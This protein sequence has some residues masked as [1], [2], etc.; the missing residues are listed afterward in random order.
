M[1]LTQIALNESEANDAGYSDTQEIRATVFP[2]LQHEIDKL[3]RRAQKLGVPEIDLIKE[4]E[5][6]RTV[7]DPNTDMETQEKWFEVTVDG[8][9]PQ[10]P[11]YKFLATIEHKGGGNVIRLVPGNENVANLQDF[12]NATPDYC[13]HC[14]KRRKRI[15]TFIIQGQDGELRQI[16]RN[17]LQDFLGGK[18]PKQM[19]FWF[20]LKAKVEQ[21][22]NTANSREEG[23]KGGRREMSYSPMEVLRAAGALVLKYGYKKKNMDWDAPDD[24]TANMVRSVLFYYNHR[25]EDHKK[26]AQIVK[27]SPDALNY[28]KKV[29]AWFNDLPDQE[30]TDNNFYHSI[31]VLLKSSDITSRDVGILG[32]IYAAYDRV[33]R[34]GEERKSKSNKH[35]GTIGDKLPKT[36][37]KVTNI[38][39]VPNRFAYNAPD[40]QLVKMED[41]EGNSYTW[42]N[43]S[44][45]EMEKDVTYDIM[46]KIKAHDEYKGRNTTTLL[47]VKAVEV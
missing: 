40:I 1:K 14:K 4:R 46:G 3:N 31:D 15:D 18:N 21:A 6:F 13:D 12:H 23:G 26:W 22:F 5:F 20:S 28:A 35:M 17:C 43:G 45:N 42:W 41:S 39:Y 11:G 19:L 30:K 34:K 9:T 16:G 36:R 37:V 32:A 33:Q 8:E 47:R 2:L 10:V 25:N 7:K 44:A 38:T 27:D 24:S 29:V